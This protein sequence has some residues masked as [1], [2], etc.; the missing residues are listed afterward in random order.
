[1]KP[2][3]RE[4]TP[5]SLLTYY[6]IYIADIGAYIHDRPDC[7]IVF[8]TQLTIARNSLFFSFSQPI[9]IFLCSQ[10]STSYPGEESS[11][12]KK[13]KKRHLIN[14]S[15]CRQFHAL[16]LALTVLVLPMTE[17][18]DPTSAPQSHKPPLPCRQ[19][20]LGGQIFNKVLYHVHVIQ[21]I[22]HHDYVMQGILL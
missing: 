19:Y 22:L 13:K 17:Q 12:V 5:F 6:S 16:C 3:K 1:M 4:T 21:G 11:L 14:E 7:K 10:E 18:L 2:L 8:Q 20:L 15:K 9:C